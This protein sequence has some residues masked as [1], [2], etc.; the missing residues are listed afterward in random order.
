M[1]A[2]EQINK[3]L[4]AENLSPHMII[5]G[6]IVTKEAKGFL[7][8]FGLKDKT[9]G[10]LAFDEHSERMQIGELVHVMVKQSLPS[11]K[12]VKCELPLK[13]GIEKPLKSKDLTIHNVKPGFLVAAKVQR[14][15]DNGIE[16]GFLGGFSGTVF[17][18]HLDKDLA[19]FKLGDKVNA[20]VV[21][22]DAMT[23]SITLSLLPHLVK[24]QNAA[25]LFQT[26]GIVVGRVFE[27]AAV[28]QVAFGDSYRVTLTPLVTGFLHKIHAVQQEKPKRKAKKEESD[29]E[30]SKVVKV[31]LEKG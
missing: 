2:L 15:L 21:S 24:L 3:S 11:S 5:Q 20:R 1:L 28:S 29:D 27:K 13:D 16:L 17:V 31:E 7:I 18:D 30:E 22:V 12:I 6:I 26:E 9:Q 4:T 14:T 23:Q 8:N 25:A 19:K 10:F